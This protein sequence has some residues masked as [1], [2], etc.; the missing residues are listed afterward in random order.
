MDLS[1]WRSMLPWNWASFHTLPGGKK[2][3]VRMEL[4]ECHSALEEAKADIVGLWV[5]NFL[6]NKNGPAATNMNT[7][8]FMMLEVC[9]MW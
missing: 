4:Q 2:S 6:I 1:F 8:K 3:T 9:K 7:Y 5:L